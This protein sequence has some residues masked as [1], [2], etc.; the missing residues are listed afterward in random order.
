MVGRELAILYGPGTWC[1]WTVLLDCRQAYQQAK[2]QV[3]L[4]DPGLLLPDA[5]LVAGTQRTQ[6]EK[7]LCKKGL[8]IEELK[9]HDQECSRVSSVP[10]LLQHHQQPCR[11]KP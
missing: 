2:E 8:Q 4:N 3:A 10:T 9:C 7:T 5:G 6:Q 1:W 11:A